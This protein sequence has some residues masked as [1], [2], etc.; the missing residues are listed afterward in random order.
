M[1]ALA[2]VNATVDTSSF[3]LTESVTTNFFDFDIFFDFNGLY[4]I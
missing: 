1:A 3:E 2:T 4:L